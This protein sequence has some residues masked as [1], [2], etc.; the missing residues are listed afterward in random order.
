M[1]YE[2]Y[3]GDKLYKTITTEGGY[4]F[5]EITEQLHKDE[6]DGKLTGFDLSKGISVKPV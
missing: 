4:K 1:K 3:I 6:V 2:I 5:N